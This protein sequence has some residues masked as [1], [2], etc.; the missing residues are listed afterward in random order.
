MLAWGSRVRS[1]MGPGNFSLH[2][3]V[4]TGSGSHPASYTVSRRGYFSGGKSGQGVKL[5]TH[6]YLMP[7]SK[8]A[9]SYT[10]IPAI[11]LHGVVLSY[12][13]GT[14]LIQWVPGVLSLEVKRPRREADHSPP[15]STRVKNA[16]RYTSTPPIR[17]HGVVL[18]YS[19]GINLP[20]LHIV[21]VDVEAK[22]DRTNTRVYPK[23]SG[24]AAWSENCK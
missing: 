4:Q 21:N 5:A 15:S 3:R 14:T 10:S 18:S 13:T 23:V 8:N 19:A 12:S 20:L 17:I 11:R 9:W 2:H 24:L 22:C 1:P 16:W 7:R 6:L